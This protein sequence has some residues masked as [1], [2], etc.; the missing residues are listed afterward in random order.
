MK[1]GR[2]YFYCASNGSL[3]KR[4]ERKWIQTE[5]ENTTKREREFSTRSREY[6]KKT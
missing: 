4:E 3:T 1:L 5:N 6:L 2:L